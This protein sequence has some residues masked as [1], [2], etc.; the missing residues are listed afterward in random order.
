MVNRIDLR[1]N[2][3]SK[4]C[5]QSESNGLCTK[6]PATTRRRNCESKGKSAKWRRKRG[7]SEVTGEGEGEGAGEAKPISKSA[8][9]KA[10]PPLAKVKALTKA[11]VK[12]K[13]KAK[14]KG[15]EAISSIFQSTL[16]SCQ[17]C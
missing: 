13:T 6:K 8:N 11:K 14:A 10:T 2:N 12:A 7:K 5:S 15:S 17:V 16:P 3:K 1:P 9:G 4:S